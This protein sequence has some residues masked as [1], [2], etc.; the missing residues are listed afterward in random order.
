MKNLDG[1][2]KPASVAVIGASRTPGSLGKMFIESLLKYEFTG[3]IYPVNPK[4]DVIDGLKCYPSVDALPDGTDMA[5]ILVRK[6]LA[7]GALEQCGEKGIKN[8]IVITAG[9]K[10]VGGEGIEREKKLI[11]IADR[12]RMQIVGPNCMGIINSDEKYSLNASFSPTAPERGGVAFISQSGALAVSILDFARDMHLGFSIFVSMGNKANLTDIDFVEYVA[13]DEATKVITMYQESVDNGAEFM[14]KIRRITKKKPVV[15][16]KA[17]KTSAGQKAASS[18]T[19]ALASSDNATQAMFDQSGILRVDTMQELCETALAFSTQPVPA[20]DNICVI[21]NSG[22]PGILATDAITKYGL[23]MAEISGE[24]EKKFREIIPEDGSAHNPIDMLA[25]GDHNMYASCVEIA[26]Q[27]DNIGAVLVI[28]V[29]PP[30]DTTPKKIIEHIGGVI[31]KYPQKPVFLA[32]MTRHDEESGKDLAAE[33]SLPVFNFPEAAAKAIAD[34]RRFVKWQNKPLGN[35]VTY[36][37]DRDKVANIIKNAQEAEREHLTDAEVREVLTAYGFPMPRFAVSGSAAE[38]VAFQKELGSPVVLKIESPD[39]L[40][41]SDIGGVKVNLHSEE[42]ITAAYEEIM[43]NA[44]KVTTAERIEG[45]MVQE[46]VS[47]GR[48]VA[49]GTVKDPNYGPMIMFGLGGIF[50]EIFKDVVFRVAPITDAEADEMMESIKGYP[51][52]KGARGEKPVDFAKLREIMLRLSQLLTDFPQ[53]MEMDVNPLLAN[54]VA[55]LT[56]AVD[57]RIRIEV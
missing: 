44:L 11:E 1:F 51:I 46:M 19:G 39:I 37:V 23:Q 9:F 27:D 26:L 10:E 57:A 36:E 50:I 4:A 8:V 48:E 20:N 49:L 17:G 47:G 13:E 7:P 3:K 35:V 56:K 15:V 22:G 52:L 18:H 38:A 6:E 28:I 55:E 43:Q 40:H 2:F 24:T 29:R 5:V 42:E 34:M 45:I 12:Y 53:I 21:T 14:D 54:P 25:A 33:Y 30:V 31:K 16:L 32:V 41:K